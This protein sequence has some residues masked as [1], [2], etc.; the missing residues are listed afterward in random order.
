MI[1]YVL[2]STEPGME[3]AILKTLQ[4]AEGIVEIHP[5]F[6]EYDIMGK[7]EAEGITHLSEIVE[8]IR[9]VEG[10]KGTKTYTGAVFK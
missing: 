8:K 3:Q 7:V 10:I 5:L 9:Q 6:G 2:I 1:A 4:K